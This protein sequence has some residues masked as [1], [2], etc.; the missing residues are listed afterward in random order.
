MEPF[1]IACPHCDAS[2]RVKSPKILG[3]EVNCPACRGPL[4]I[5]LE[6]QDEEESEVMAGV[7]SQVS[8]INVKG[9]SLREGGSSI[10]DYGVSSTYDETTQSYVFDDTES[11]AAQ[12]NLAEE[13]SASDAPLFSTKAK[14]T[15][16]ERS[17][18]KRSP[19]GGYKRDKSGDWV[20]MGA[21]C[22]VSLL[23]ATIFGIYILA[24]KGYFSSDGRL[25]RQDATKFAEL[26]RSIDV[27]KEWP[28]ANTR[29]VAFENQLSRQIENAIDQYPQAR[30][31]LREL[32]AR[33]KRIR[34]GRIKN[35]G[36]Y[37]QQLVGLQNEVKKIIKQHGGSVQGE[38]D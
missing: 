10:V 21:V 32:Q 24:W 26:G 22:G 35:Y 38:H 15:Y 34:T 6:E 29:P 23:L 5:V 28:G 2:M 9:L 17:E 37:Q 27:E 31:E 8:S 33:F 36:K 7:A 4:V 20:V 14:P 30:S 1:E 3:K 12:E 18:P 13:A 19:Q 25:D 11:E 16:E